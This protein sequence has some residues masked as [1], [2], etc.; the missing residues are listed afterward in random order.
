MTFNKNYS[1]TKVL[2]L[3]IMALVFSSGLFAAKTLDIKNITKMLDE[4]KIAKEHKNINSMKK[5]F[6]SRTSVSLTEQ[7]IEETNTKRLSFNEY[8]RYLSRYW[9]DVQSNLIEVK[10]RKIDIADNGKSALVKSTFVQT[11][12]IKGVKIET[13]IYETTGI[14]LIKG[15]IY[16][17]YFSSRKMLN[18]SLRVN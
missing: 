3:S 2:F 8:K 17:N 6:L 9:R 12:E 10:E 15:K 7:N 11:V 4:V 5:H 16:I 1:F 18:T 13:T 14:S